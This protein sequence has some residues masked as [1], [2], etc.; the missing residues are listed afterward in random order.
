MDLSGHRRIAAP[1]ARAWAAL[2]DPQMLRRAMPGCEVLD[3]VSDD[4][5][6]A[7]VLCRIGPISFRLTGR[8]YLSDLEP[9]SSCIIAGEG[10]GLAGFA[11]GAVRVDLI[12]EGEDVVVTY[13]VQANVD[14]K[15]A[16][17]G[18]RLLKGAARRFADEFLERLDALLAEE[19]EPS[20]G[21]Y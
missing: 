18:L 10:T 16:Q 14:G 9:P 1:R 11:H 12:E 2:N 19:V 21:Q 6:E 5:F 7:C 4:E 3:K 15:L 8:M 17:I 20:P 13:A